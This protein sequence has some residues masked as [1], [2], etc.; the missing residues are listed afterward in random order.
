VDSEFV[1]FGISLTESLRQMEASEVSTPKTPKKAEIRYLKENEL[2]SEFNECD[3]DNP[4]TVLRTVENFELYLN[5]TNE[6]I[7]F[8]SIEHYRGKVMM[9][10]VVIESLPN[11]IKEKIANILST[12]SVDVENAVPRAATNE[13]VAPTTSTDSGAP[14]P[15]SVT[16]PPPLSASSAPVTLKLDWSSLKVGDYVDGYCNKTFHWYEAKITAFNEKNHRYK[17]HFQGWNS[18]YDEWIDQYSE[19]LIPHKASAFAVKEAEKLATQLIPWFAESAKLQ[20][21]F[22]TCLGINPSV[23]KKSVHVIVEDI[24]DWCVDYTYANPTLWLISSAGIWYRVAGALCPTGGPLGNPTP[25]YLSAFSITREKYLTAAHVVMALMDVLP[26]HPTANFKMIVDEVTA[27][28]LNV[29]NELTILDHYHFLLEQISTIENPVDWSSKA[30]IASCSFLT[31]LQKEGE[32]YE[33][34]GGIDTIRVREHRF[35]NFL[36]I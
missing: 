27:R 28:T 21:H 3:V 25:A 19:R 34:Y 36:N 29:V 5:D 2:S 26:N 22:Q 15:P 33:S 14:V 1:C 18:K 17:V 11:A 23:K 9:K 16:S 30:S 24:D 10:C 6:F 13:S 20:S 12:A 4:E 7:D 8:D 35:L 31:Q 32:E